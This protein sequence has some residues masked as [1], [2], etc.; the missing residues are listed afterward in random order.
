LL[1]ESTE[2]HRR[3]DTLTAQVIANLDR[4]KADADCIRTAHQPNFL[5]SVNIVGQ[6]AACHLLNRELG[7]HHAEVFFVLDY[8]VNDDRRYRHATFPSLSSP[9]GIW[10]VSA[11]AA[12]RLAPILM[13]REPLPSHEFL[14]AIVPRIQSWALQQIA[15]LPRSHRSK[16]LKD[17]VARGVERLRSVVENAAGKATGLADFNAMVL[18]WVVNRVLGLPTMFL[19]GSRALPSVA[20]HLQ[21][22]WHSREE[23]VRASHSAEPAPVGADGLSSDTAPFWKQCPCGARL[24]LHESADRRRCS[25]RCQYCGASGWVDDRNIGEV[26][27]EGSLVPK[28]LVDDLLDG[29]A[30]GNIAGCDYRG[31]AR[32]YMQSR[33]VAH[34]LALDPLPVWLSARSPDRSI[35][36]ISGVEMSATLTGSTAGRLGTAA[37]HRLIASGRASAAL[38][39]LWADRFAADRIV[40]DFTGVSAGRSG[41]YE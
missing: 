4:Y 24:A 5:A 16:E 15:V 10:T 3:A 30:W 36:H 29:T 41:G 40:E 38:P 12:R 21:A 9:H 11:G 33:L 20:D 25:Y 31:G 13:H 35:E 39:L 17:R 8:D 32:H 18:S 26:C 2:F 34:S 6:A 22:A 19:P 1:R 37:A 27:A 28:V 7:G 14:G 23:I